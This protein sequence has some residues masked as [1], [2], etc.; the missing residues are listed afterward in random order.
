MY[1]ELPEIC[2]RILSNIFEHSE[3]NFRYDFGEK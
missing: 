1:E 2:E 3:R